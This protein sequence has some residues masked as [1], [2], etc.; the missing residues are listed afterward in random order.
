MLGVVVT[1]A[2]VPTLVSP[3]LKL[4]PLPPLTQP[5]PPPQVQD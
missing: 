3:T 4:T 2:P 1:P 5:P